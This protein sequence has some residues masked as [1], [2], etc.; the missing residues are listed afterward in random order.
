M[1]GLLFIASHFMTSFFGLPR[2]H[3]GDRVNLGEEH[4]TASPFY[5]TPFKSLENTKHLNRTDNT[6]KT[7]SLFCAKLGFFKKPV[8]L[9][10]QHNQNV[11]QVNRFFTLTHINSE[12]FCIRVWHLPT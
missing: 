9:F 2:S 11:Y 5:V 8:A 10:V 7:T 12:L 6:H 1:Q 4:F 3:C